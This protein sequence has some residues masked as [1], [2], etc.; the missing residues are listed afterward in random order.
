MNNP[1]GKK[2]QNERQFED[3]INQWLS[4]NKGVEIV[5]VEQSASGG[6]FGPSLW[7]ISIWYEEK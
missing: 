4:E 2:R 5:R 1:W 3:E 7:M 6:S